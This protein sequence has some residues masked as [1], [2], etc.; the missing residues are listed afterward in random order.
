MFI[1]TN[2][3][4]RSIAYRLQTLITT[5]DKKHSTDKI[6]FNEWELITF[7]LRNQDFYLLTQPELRLHVALTPKYSTD[8]VPVLQK[9]LLA[10]AFP[11]TYVE[12][13]LKQLTSKRR[14]RATDENLPSTF[15]PASLTKNPAFKADL[16]AI[17][18][19]DFDYDPT[20]SL[21]TLSTLIT[22]SD[23]DRETVAKARTLFTQTFAQ[24]PKKPAKTFKYV[25]VQPQFDDYYQWADLSFE[26]LPDKQV[27]NKVHQNNVDLLAQ[28]F[29]QEKLTLKKLAP[30]EILHDLLTS[31][32][33][34]Y[35]MA[36][37]FK[38]IIS[39]LASPAS[40]LYLQWNYACKELNDLG[41]AF[42]LIRS[43]EQSL[44]LLYQFLASCGVI[45]KKDAKFVKDELDLTLDTIHTECLKELT[46]NQ[47]IQLLPRY[48]DDE[49]PNLETADQILAELYQ[50]AVEQPTVKTPYMK[51]HKPK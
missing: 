28:F 31:Y 13:Y 51:L 4:N 3:I 35:L 49:T 34:E 26:A 47:I 11:P 45:A 42:D 12:T 46:A 32:L 22:L 18:S 44:N 10:L 19:E 9:T 41:H 33:D 29:A 5:H 21:T 6:K 37:C 30:L 1:K 39:D 38:T 24:A 40:F 17:F 48:D 25:T 15:K 43:F 2:P 27:L 14:T 36:D 50:F 16:D 8:F 20:C 23:Y 7:T